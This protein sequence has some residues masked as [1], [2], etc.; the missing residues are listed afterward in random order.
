MT[1]ES[2]LGSIGEFAGHRPVR[3]WLDCSGQTLS[4]AQ[5]QALYSLIGTTYGG[6]GVQN[7]KI[8]DLRP[9]GSDGQ[10]DTG[11][12]HRIDWTQTDQ[13]KKMICIEGLYPPFD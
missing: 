9:W 7:F 13:P 11:H 6:D 3:G 12:R 10:P 5:N 4:I 2:Y 1:P 8:P